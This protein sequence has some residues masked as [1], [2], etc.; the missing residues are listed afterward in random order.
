MQ[1]LLINP[2]KWEELYYL[3]QGISYE[4]QFFQED[5]FMLLIKCA[6][7]LLSSSP[8]T[9]THTKDTHFLPQTNEYSGYSWVEAIGWQQIATRIMTL[10][11]SL[12]F[13]PCITIFFFYIESL[14]LVSLKGHFSKK[15]TICSLVK[16]LCTP[17]YNEKQ[18]KKMTAPIYLAPRN[19]IRYS[20]E[21]MVKNTHNF[22]LNPSTE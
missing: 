19:K 7:S 2:C 13:F 5:F 10:F 8:I 21:K 20:I 1:E 3:Y 11:D 22:L 14:S 12:T 6:G 17:I 9:H 16:R 18:S 4:N 15:H